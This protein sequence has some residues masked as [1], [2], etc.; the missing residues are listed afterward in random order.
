MTKKIP[1][2]IFI[3]LVAGLIYYNL[4]N[5]DY[6][7]GAEAPDFSLAA[8]DGA[9]VSLSDYQ[10]DKVLLMFWSGSCSSC[11]ESLPEIQQL[12]ERELAD[13]QILTISL[14]SNVEQLNEIMESNNYQFEVLLDETNEV[15]EEYLVNTFPKLVVIDEQGRIESEQIGAFDY[16]DLEELIEDS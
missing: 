7:I 10:G 8:L 3:I 15:S 4:P 14:T 12:Y 6:E 13:F 16:Q 2:L 5:Y 11:L 1:Y 9:E